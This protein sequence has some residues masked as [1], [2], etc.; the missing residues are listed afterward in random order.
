ME[1]DFKINKMLTKKSLIVLT[2]VLIMGIFSMRGALTKEIVIEDGDKE[3]KVTTVSARVENVLNKGMVTLNKH[4]QVLPTL[5]EKVDENMK[6]V[7]KRAYPITLEVG[8]KAEEVMTANVQVKD[9]LEEYNV[10]LGDLDRVEPGLEEDIEKYQIINVVRINEEVVK[11]NVT[12][13]YDSII[14]YRDDLEK[15]KVN[16]LKKGKAGEKEIQY[17]VVYED[18]KEVERELI[19]E[20]VVYDAEN[21]VVEQGTVQYVATS[22]GNLRTKK[23]IRMTSTAYDAGF[24]STGK[25]PGDKHYGITRSGTTVRPGVVAVD[26]KVIPLGSKLYI[27]SLDGSKDYGFASAEDTGGAIKGNKIDLYFES[28]QDV[29]KYG[30]RTVKVYILN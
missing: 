20:N 19:E 28:A 16:L 10:V 8:G 9:V 12:I 2:I 11:E 18:G 7:I 3:I 13:P 26:P 5:G 17:K 25:K 30:R 27:E 22:R 6:I 24:E 1:T 15:G 21:E 23:I 14:K 29:K 4:D